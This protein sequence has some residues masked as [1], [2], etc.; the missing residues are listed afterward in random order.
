MRIEADY[1]RLDAETLCRA[2]ASGQLSSTHLVSHFLDRVR[3]FD[4]RLNCF[5]SLDEQRVLSEAK[6]RDAHREAGGRLGLLHGLPVSIKDVI[7]VEG[8]CT[9]AHSKILAD[10]VATQDSDVVALLRQQGAVI[11]GKTATHEFAI[12]GP[13][14]DL[15][16]PPARNPWNTAHHPGGSSSGAGAGLAAGL[17]PAAIG[18]DTAG[19]VRNPATHCGVVGLKPA[20]G[21]ISLRGVFPLSYS[22]DCVGPMATTVSGCA[23]LFAALTANE[24]YVSSPDIANASVSGMRIGALRRWHRDD[25]EAEPQMADAFEH[26]IAALSDAGGQVVEVD[27]GPLQDFAAAAFVIRMSEAYTIHRRWLAERPEDYGTASRNRISAGA[28]F[29]AADYI[30]ALRHAS[31]LRESWEKATSRVDAVLTLSSFD[32]SCAIDDMA[33]FEA[34]YGRQARAPINLIGYPAL[35][36]PCGFTCD[37][38]P[39]GVQIVSRP[40]D[41]TAL[42][43]L[44]HAIEAASLSGRYPPGFGEETSNPANHKAIVPQ[45]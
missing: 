44:G 29:S 11:F 33:T 2:L 28:Y 6:Q 32:P 22:L 17:F 3:R 45:P 12:G 13:S 18:T 34:N 1:H 5:V 35:A 27:P 39:L 43:A 21:Q 10:C 23:R 8:M 36:V 7:D 15:P 41:E 9:T 25:F 26:A 24:T 37:G 16:W 20:A 40:G 42:M 4:N 30:D 14:F 38:L 31:L 19:S